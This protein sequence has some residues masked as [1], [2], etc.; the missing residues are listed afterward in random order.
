MEP[1]TLNELNPYILQCGHLSA[2]NCPPPGA[3]FGMRRVKWFELELI[4]NGEGRIITDGKAL[5]ACRGGLFFRRPGM[6]ADGISPYESY[7]VIFDPVK[8]NARI[9]E[10]NSGNFY[11]RTSEEDTAGGIPLAKSVKG[12]ELPDI[13]KVANV[14]RYRGVFEKIYSGFLSQDPYAQFFLKAYL[15][16][17]L[18]MAAEEWSYNG[19]RH[20]ASRSVRKNSPNIYKVK[21]HIDKNTGRNF[22]LD[23]LAAMADLSPGFFCKLFKRIVGLSPVTYINTNKLNLAKELLIRTNMPIKQISLE[24]GFENDTYFY[25]LFK[26][27]LG[28]SPLHFREKYGIPALFR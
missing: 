17:L 7:L 27:R 26:S 19:R 23:Q 10:Y 8:D 6:M 16:Q 24:C 13:M 9:P 28:I 5:D 21:D 3:H 14:E 18:V 12:L 1:Y 2:A 11:N 25:T 4:I 15:M 20:S 22:K